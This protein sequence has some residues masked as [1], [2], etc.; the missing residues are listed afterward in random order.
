[1]TEPGRLVRLLMPGRAA[2]APNLRM[3]L[4]LCMPFQLGRI[5]I[6]LP[7]V[8]GCV[9]FGL[10]VKVF[11]S[12]DPRFAARGH[13]PCEHGLSE[14]NDGDKTIPARAVYLL[15]AFVWPRAE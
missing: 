9:A 15:R 6:H 7:Q 4:F 5:K 14:F 10:V 3:I 12:D 11:R 1:M 8:A 13:G 2:R